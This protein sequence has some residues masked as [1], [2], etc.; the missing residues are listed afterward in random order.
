MHIPTALLTAT[1]IVALTAAAN[2]Q[3]QAED[4]LEKR[5]ASQAEHQPAEIQRWGRYSP[6]VQSAGAGRYRNWMD[7]NA[8][9]TSF[10]KRAVASAGMNL[11]A[12]RM[13]SP[14]LSDGGGPLLAMSLVDSSQQQSD[15][16]GEGAK[17]IMNMKRLDRNIYHVGFGR[18]RK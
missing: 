14:M 6:S 4:G 11:N 1:L 2:G 18:R 10:G 8:Y 15:D 16:S 7:G 9:R 5:T 12:F 17:T 3:Q 13:G